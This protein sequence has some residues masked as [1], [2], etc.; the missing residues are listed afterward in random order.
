MVV[1][2]GIYKASISNGCLV[3]CKMYDVCVADVEDGGRVCKK[4]RKRD[5]AEVGG[6]TPGI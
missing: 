6:G 5:Q 4:E 2:C 1:I 3:R